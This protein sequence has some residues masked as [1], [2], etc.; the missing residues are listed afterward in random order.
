VIGELRAAGMATLI[1]DRDYRR[2][3]ASSDRIVVLQ[4]GRVALCGNSREL[5]EGPALA[6]L[7]G[8]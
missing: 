2:V 7:L 6:A 5:L 8:V 1:V 4:K 3:A